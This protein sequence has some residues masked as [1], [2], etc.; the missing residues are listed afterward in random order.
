MK[1]GREPKA[2]F[3]DRWSERGIP[4]IPGWP[5]L[6][7][8][9]KQHKRLMRGEESKHLVHVMSDKHRDVLSYYRFS[10][11]G[12]KFYVLINDTTGRLITVYNQAMFSNRKSAKKS[13]KRY[14]SMRGMVGKKVR[15]AEKRGVN[16]I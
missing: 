5:L 10:I 6:K 7:Y 11:K 2:H 15:A 12:Q 1:G 9:S 4:D 16:R 14:R 8:L 3:I 13:R